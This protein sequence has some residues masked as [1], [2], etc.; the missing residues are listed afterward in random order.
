MPLQLISI[1]QN[2]CG[3]LLA[4]IQFYSSSAA[5]QRYLLTFCCHVCSPYNVS[6]FLVPQIDSTIE[7]VNTKRKEKWNLDGK[8]RRMRMLH[9]KKF[10][11]R[12]L[13]SRP[14]P[15]EPSEN[16][17]TG[18]TTRLSEPAKK[19]EPEE[20][21]EE[22]EEEEDKDESANESEAADEG[23]VNVSSGVRGECDAGRYVVL[24]VM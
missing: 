2:G 15:P 13:Q 10:A 1:I 11:Q 21:K 4:F 19:E 7:V 24:D 20:H 9:A 8:L 18:D 12:H 23:D 22:D 16:G 17:D 6:N 5:L 14:V 3:T